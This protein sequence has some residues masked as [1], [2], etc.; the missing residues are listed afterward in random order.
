MYLFILRLK[1]INVN[2]II[3]RNTS[4]FVLVVIYVHTCSQLMRF[5]FLWAFTFTFALCIFFKIWRKVGFQSYKLAAIYNYQRYSWLFEKMFQ[6]CY[7]SFCFTQ[8]I[9][10]IDSQLYLTLNITTTNIRLLVSTSPF[11]VSDRH[12]NFLLRLPLENSSVYA[13]IH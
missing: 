13:Q 2:K 1:I 5:P 9:V 7:V 12:G 4:N 10:F 6:C 11:E 3:Y 8:M